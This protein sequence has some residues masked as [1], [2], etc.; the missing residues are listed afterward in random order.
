MR[1]FTCD[2]NI[3]INGHTMMAY[4]DNVRADILQPILTQYVDLPIDVNKWYPLQPLLHVLKTINE[5][6]SATAN[7]VAIGVK[8]AEYG[9]EP[10]SMNKADLGVVLEHWEEHMYRNIRNGDVGRIIT[11]KVNDQFYKV[12][13]K[14]IFPDDM[15]Y[16][17]AYGFA[18]SRLPLGTNFKVWYEDFDNRID[19]GDADETTICISWESM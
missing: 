6:P 16:G 11:E 2:P 12:T 18:R 15:C 13:Q 1:T 17:L 3:E 10:D 8:L 7:L 19:R 4:V 14:N 9:L 5:S